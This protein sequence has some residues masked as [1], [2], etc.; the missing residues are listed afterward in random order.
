MAPLLDDVY[1]DTDLLVHDGWRS[2]PG[3]DSADFAPA[4]AACNDA[5]PGKRRSYEER[6]ALLY[7]ACK[8]GGGRD[9]SNPVF[10]TLLM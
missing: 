4:R 5:V 7:N 10:E 2:C 9:K 6:R 8:A 3:G 1:K